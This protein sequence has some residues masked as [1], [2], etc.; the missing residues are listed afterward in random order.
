MTELLAIGPV[1]AALITGVLALLTR[2]WPRLQ[3]VVTVAGTVGYACVVGLLCWEVVFASDAARIVYQLGGWRAPFGITLV[4]DGL[5]VFMLAMTGVVAVYAA[6]FSVRFIDEHNQ[7]VYY[8][9][10]FQF[11][12]LGATGAFLTG[13][14]FNLFV[15]FE[16]MLMTSYVFVAFYGNDSHTAAAMRYLVL[17][18]VGSALMLLGVGGLYAT[19]GTLNMA[20]MARVLAADGAAMRPVVGVSALVFVTFALKGGLVP[21]QFWVPGAYRAAPLPIVAM[22]VGV[23]KKVGI[24]AIIRLYFTIFGTATV[25]VDVPGVAGDTPLAFLAPVLLVMAALSIVVG[26]LG[27]LTRDSLEGLF[28]Y[29]SIGQIGFIAVPIGIAA[30]TTSETLRKT[31]LL[32]GLIFAL[33]H[34][35]TKG[36]LFLGTGVI[37]DTTG[38]TQLSEL[39][40]LGDRSPA[41]ASVFLVGTLS[42]AGIPPLAGFFGKFLVFDTAGRRFASQTAGGFWAV[43][44]ASGIL[45]I[46]LLGALLTILYSTRAWIGAVWGEET[47]LVAGNSVDAGEVVILATLSVLVIAVG[48]GF[49]PV[50]EFAEAAAESALDTDGYIDA[51]LG[52]ETG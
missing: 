27:A 19:T 14:L 38:T 39:G 40:G 11:L 37:R 16:V 28:A 22:F 9:P 32:A 44:G 47:G 42:L 34:A 35:L 31:G 21:F 4:A 10:L 26:G 46:L 49:E 30:A 20:D 33:H 7:Q 45:G 25:P 17:N 1:L 5:S 48:V 50:Y 12:L 29:S 3:R 6:V 36:L 52:G 8:Y 23:T 2:S 43:A 15:W 24:Y 13:D 41:F 18:I 51:V